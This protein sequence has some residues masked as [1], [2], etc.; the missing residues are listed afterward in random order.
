MKKIYA[1]YVLA[2]AALL[3]SGCSSRESTDDK[4][5]KAAVITT[6]ADNEADASDE[7]NMETDQ[8][9]SSVSCSEITAAILDQ[10]EMSS[11][12]E[13]GA[14]RVAN[15]LD[16]G[17]TD[18]LSFSMYI[19]GSGGFADEIAVFDLSVNDEDALRAAIESRVQ[20]RM[21]DFEEYNPDEFDKLGEAVLETIGN[22]LVFSVSPDNDKVLD[23]A[24]GIIE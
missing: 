3:I 22:Y 10:V 1:V 9:M 12:A 14:D 5:P 13:V 2:A 8:S 4:I 21:K 16:A 11:M 23:I 7:N 18:D 6:A 19:C 17:L 24:K 20:S 15:Y